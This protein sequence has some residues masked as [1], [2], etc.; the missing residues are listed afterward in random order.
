MYI[1]HMTITPVSDCSEQTDRPWL[2]KPGQSGN[3]AG[4]PP[5]AG[6]RQ[7]ALQILDEVGNREDNAQ[8][9]SAAFDAA[10]KKNPLQF[11]LKVMAPLL[12][13]EALLKVEK[14]G[15]CGPWVSLI[16]VARLREIEQR[17]IAAGLELPPP[18]QRLARNTP[19]SE[20]EAAGLPPCWPSPTRLP[21]IT[22]RE[23][24][25]D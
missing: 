12:P 24:G 25:R 7:R 9:L 20:R 13:R 8:L 3:K 15:D 14:A 16:E 21:P 5:G 23:P 18:A 2:F 19:P 1:E 22:A 17:A 11:F 4:R 6:G 10:F